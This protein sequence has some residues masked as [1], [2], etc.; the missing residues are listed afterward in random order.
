[1][2]GSKLSVILGIVLTVIMIGTLILAAG[3]SKATTTATTKPATT[4]QPATTKVTTLNFC[5][6]HPAQ[7]PMVSVINEAEKRHLWDASGHTIKLNVIPS[8]GA[9]S[10]ASE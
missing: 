8:A 3:C 6:Q 1:M 9:V 2:K 10:A 5:V 7:D 4:T